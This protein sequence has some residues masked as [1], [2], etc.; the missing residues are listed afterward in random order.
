MR[1]QW[2]LA[3]PALALAAALAGCGDFCSDNPPMAAPTS[4]SERQETSGGTAAVS[5]VAEGFARDGSRLN[6]V[7]KACLDDVAQRLKAD[8]RA[9]VVL[10]GHADSRENDPDAV[11]RRRA[12]AVQDYL[13]REGGIDPYRAKLRSRPPDAG[14]DDAAMAHNRRCEV[15]LVPEGA[16]DPD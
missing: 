10:V 3:V 12:R 15:W 4:A 7:D 6:N 8:P 1:R 5:C 2:M 13:A 16:P 9:H 14:G 11:A